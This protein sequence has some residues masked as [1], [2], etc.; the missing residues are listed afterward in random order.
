M[1]VLVNTGTKEAERLS[2]HLTGVGY[3]N[4]QQ[5]MKGLQARARD[6]AVTSIPLDRRK[7]TGNLWL[8]NSEHSSPSQ[9]LSLFP[10]LSTTLAYSPFPYSKSKNFQVQSVF[11]FCTS[12]C[13]PFSPFIA[14]TP[15]Q[16]S[17]LPAMVAVVVKGG[18]N[19]NTNITL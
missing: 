17:Y 7:Y 19:S 3:I 13:I 10:S 2:P 9:P 11:Y 4:N 6:K 1:Y 16:F 15:I 12:L 8:K 14:H 18:N 5:S